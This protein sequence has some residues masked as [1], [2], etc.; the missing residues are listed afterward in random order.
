MESS[1]VVFDTA[2]SL[3]G[4]VQTAESARIDGL[5]KFGPAIAHE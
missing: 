2:H 4:K 3:V 1:F 5:E